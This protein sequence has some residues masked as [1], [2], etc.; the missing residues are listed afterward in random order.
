MWAK[1]KKTTG[2]HRQLGFTIVELLIVIVVIG[3]LAAIVIVAYNGVQARSK[4]SAVQSDMRNSATKIGMYYVDNS[5]YPVSQA[6]IQPIMARTLTAYDSTN[7]NDYLYCRSDT[8]FAVIV[9]SSPQDAFAYT[10]KQGAIKL[11]SWPGNGNAN[12]CPY[13]GI[14]TTDPGYNYVWVYANGVWAW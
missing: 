2:R 3:I 9:R 10:A 14:N 4:A 12:L 1:Q 5:A 13:V 6:N 7:L 11:A 8:D